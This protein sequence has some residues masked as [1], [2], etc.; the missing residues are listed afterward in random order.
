MKMYSCGFAKRQ[1]WWIARL[2]VWAVVPLRPGMA[3]VA[4]RMWSTYLEMA[5]AFILA[6]TSTNWWRPAGRFPGLGG[7]IRP[8]V[9]I[10]KFKAPDGA[11]TS[12]PNH[13]TVGKRA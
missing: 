12:N 3:A 1:P 4:P 11:L 10:A 7:A 8:K 13:I 5:W 9:S 6:S 2:S